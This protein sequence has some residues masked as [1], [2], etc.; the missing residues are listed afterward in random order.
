MRVMLFAAARAQAGVSSIELAVPDGVRVEALLRAVGEHVP[1][2]VNLLPKL[3]VAVNQ[4]FAAN[5]DVIPVGAEVALIPPVAG[6]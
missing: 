3:R 5:D 1:A 2:L 6:G 4:E